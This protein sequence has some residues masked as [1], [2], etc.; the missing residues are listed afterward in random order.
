MDGSGLPQIPYSSYKQLPYGNVGDI[1][2]CDH[3]MA[4]PRGITTLINGFLLSL[5]LFTEN[6]NKREQ[7]VKFPPASFCEWIFL[8]S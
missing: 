2:V 3:H 1:L 5:S 6:D 8:F 7:N 4:L